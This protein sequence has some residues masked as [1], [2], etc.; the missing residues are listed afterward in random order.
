MRHCIKNSAPPPGFGQGTTLKMSLHNSFSYYYGLIVSL[1]DKN[2]D[3]R[4]VPYKHIFD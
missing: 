4:A 1:N 2:T 3:V